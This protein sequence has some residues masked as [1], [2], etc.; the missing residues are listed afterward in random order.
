ML[1]Q[2]QKIRA[3]YYRLYKKDKISNHNIR[4]AANEVSIARFIDG[5]IM[6]NIGDIGKSGIIVF[7]SA[8]KH[9]IFLLMHDGH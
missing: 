7:I 5:G 3:V 4:I 8:G 1:W 9:D 2:L 6:K